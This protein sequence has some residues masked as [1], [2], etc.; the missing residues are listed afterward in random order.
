MRWDQWFKGLLISGAITG[1]VYGA[2]SMADGEFT[3]K[4]AIMLAGAF[5]GGAAL[6]MKDHPPKSDDDYVTPPAS[7]G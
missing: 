5:L 3:K 4:E 7:K 2:A 6:Y 1:A